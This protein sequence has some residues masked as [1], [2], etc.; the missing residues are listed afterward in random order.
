MYYFLYHRNSLF[1]MI[2][3]TDSKLYPALTRRIVGISLLSL[4]NANATQYFLLSANISRRIKDRSRILLLVVGFITSSFSRHEVLDAD[5]IWTRFVLVGNE[6]SHIVTDP[7]TT[8]KALYYLGPQLSP[9]S[10]LL[11]PTPNFFR[12]HSRKLSFFPILL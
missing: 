8:H 5:G 6:G 11:H 4:L 2:G 9:L 3:S 12:Y 10:S 7:L 1:L